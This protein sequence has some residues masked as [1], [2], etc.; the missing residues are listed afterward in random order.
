MA[1][2]KYKPGTWIQVP[3]K[4]CLVGRDPIQ[5]MVYVWLC[6]FGED[7]YPSI[8][9]LAKLVG[10]SKSTV[11]RALSELKNDGLIFTE[12]RTDARGFKTSNRYYVNLT[13]P[14][15]DMTWKEISANLTPRGVMGEPSSGVMGEPGSIQKEEYNFNNIDTANAL[16]NSDETSEGGK[17]AIASKPETSTFTSEAVAE[18]SKKGKVAIAGETRKSSSADYGAD[19]RSSSEG[20]K[21]PNARRL[22]PT[23]STFEASTQ[24]SEGRKPSNTR[25]PPIMDAPKTSPD[26]RVSDVGGDG[27]GGM[28]RAAVV[29][30]ATERQSRAAYMQVMRKVAATAKR[31]T[32]YTDN[33]RDLGD[34]VARMKN[35]KKTVIANLGWLIDEGYSPQSITRAITEALKQS[36]TETTDSGEERKLPSNIAMYLGVSEDRRDWL[37]QKMQ[38]W[39]KPTTDERKQIIDE[40]LRGE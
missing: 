21:L 16:L 14:C 33:G 40:I 1:K 29:K 6:S 22:S 31:L 19:C 30:N 5:S 23:T 4:G 38:R 27:T 35:N 32:D 20:G 2:V 39:Y 18:D 13:S 3:A 36:R 15:A 28:E 26:W 10:K 34:Q 9:T 12:S 24:T 8:D 7:I 17:V 25:K 37:L 11:K